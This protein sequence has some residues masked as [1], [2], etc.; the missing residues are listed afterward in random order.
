MK[1]KIAQVIGLNTDQKAAQVA[2]SIRGDDNSLLAVLE[3]TSDDAFTSGRQ[4][5]SELEDFYF[6]FEGTMAEKLNATFK[7]AEKKIPE[8]AEFDL[9]L[10]AISGKALYLIGKGNVEVYLKRADTLSALLSVGTPSQLISGFLQDGDKILLSTRSLITLLGDELEKSLNLPIETFEEELGSK[11]GASS[12]ENESLAGLIVEISP[13]AGG[14]NLEISPLPSEDNGQT[15]QTDQE[16]GEDFPKKSRVLVFKDI[17]NQVLNLLKKIGTHFPRSGRGRLVVAVVLIIIIALGVGY[18]YKSGR[19]RAKAL[20]FIQTLQEAKDDFN[21]AKGLT[22]LNPLEAKKKL[23]SAKDKVKSALTLKPNDGEAQNFKNQIEQESSAILQES[24]V[25]DFPLF[26][27]M[28]LVKK[29]FRA[30]QMSL[31]GD[32][33]LL[34]DPAVKTLA[35]VDI[36]KKSNQIL[37]GSEQLGEASFASLN[38][39]LAFIY[40]VDKGIL[41]IDTTNSKLSTVAKQD[42]GWGEIKDLYGFGS[43][44]YLLNSGQIWKYVATSDGYS[45]KREY[46]SKGATADFSNALRMQIES[47][48]YV[49]KSGGEI[50]RFTKGDKD[51]FSYAG[52]PSGVKDPKSLFTSSDVDNLYLLD[53]GNSRLLILTKTGSYKGQITGNK[54]ATATDLVVDEK[55]K[56]VY[57][58][59][60]SKIFQADLK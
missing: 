28:D 36:A 24:V 53:S 54:F 34:L 3:L 35:V 6:E 5:L 2:S 52:L 10:A 18:Q 21:A 20:Q 27:D 57:L 30:T 15:V 47:S 44:V 14:E 9:C 22:S 29:N 37:A 40:S 55:G 11:I 49:L 46:L 51:N 48:V 38:G 42:S 13:P 39:G 33:L 26:L 31:S 56:K 60:G 12:A 17:L 32:K 43:N 8:G 1:L 23:D 41:R 45:D 50:L 16:I 7:E 25:S 59:E 58:L 4:I 19:D